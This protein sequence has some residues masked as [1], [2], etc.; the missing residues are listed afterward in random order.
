MQIAP[1]KKIYVAVKDA[2]YLAVINNPNGRGDAC[3]FQ[4]EGFFLD[5]RSWYGLPG[6]I[7]TSETKINIFGPAEKCE[8]DSMQLSC[9][10]IDAVEFKWYGPN[11]FYS[12]E[13]NPVIYDLK[14]EMSGTYKCILTYKDKYV[15]S[16]SVDVY[17][18]KVYFD[19]VNSLDFEPLPIG[20]R[21]YRE[22]Q[23][24]NSSEFEIIIDEP[25][26]HGNEPNTFQFADMAYNFPYTMQPEEVVTFKIQYYPVEVRDYIDSI[27][28]EVV[29]PCYLSDTEV[30]EGVGLTRELYVWLP[31]IETKLEEDICFNVMAVL[32]CDTNIKYRSEYNIE[33]R[34]DVTA[35]L[36]ES[37]INM[38]DNY[39]D[40]S[41]RVIIIESDS[42]DFSSDTISLATICGKVYLG[43]EDRT[44]LKF[45]AFNWPD[46]LITVEKNRIHIYDGSIAIEPFCQ[47]NLSRVASLFKSSLQVSPNPVTDFIEI[48]SNC[49]QTGTYSIEIFNLNG[50]SVKKI[51][52]QVNNDDN[53]KQ[54]HSFNIDMSGYSTGL[55]QLNFSCPNEIITKQIAVIK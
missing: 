15:D 44:E 34:H 30:I 46:T 7:Q 52:W 13:Q 40:G 24:K 42:V 28:I 41:D 1:D 31:N 2:K 11:N 35:F 50:I 20:E 6:K 21:E 22:I 53:L 5:A 14:V 25:K 48:I 49:R 39:I 47:S 4:I 29:S 16:S 8:N 36:P 26:I 37:G 55:Y 32:E 19:N 38:V 43:L 12:E 18:Q 17:V 54:E 9:S 33:I 51:N 3:D 45:S 23:Y 27:S 10:S